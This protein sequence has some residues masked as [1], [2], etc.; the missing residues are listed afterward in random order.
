MD[1][2][3]LWHFLYSIL[4]SLY[5]VIFSLCAWNVHSLFFFITREYKSSTRHTCMFNA[6]H[7]DAGYFLAS[8]HVFYFNF[9]LFFFFSLALFILRLEKSVNTFALNIYTHTYKDKC[10][11]Q[12]GNTRKCFHSTKFRFLFSIS[13]AP[14]YI[15][16]FFWTL[17]ILAKSK[18]SA[19]QFFFLLFSS[20]FKIDSSSQYTT[21]LCK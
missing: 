21:F 3:F 19:R 17:V 9:N 16:F 12:N 4:L 20:S 6:H 8:Y 2:E 11:L 10:V 13:F 18:L 1:C 7:F 15:R 14:L 5:L